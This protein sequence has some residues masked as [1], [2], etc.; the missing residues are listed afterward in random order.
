M[1]QV[2]G[3][4]RVIVKYYCLNFNLILIYVFLFNLVHIFVSLIQFCPI[5][6]II[7]IY[8]LIHFL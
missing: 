1:F 3:V 4:S 8:F 6:L 5:F 7:E 2:L